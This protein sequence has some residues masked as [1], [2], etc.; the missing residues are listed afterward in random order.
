MHALAENSGLTIAKHEASHVVAAQRLGV[1]VLRV[2]I[3]PERPHVTT[4]IWFGSTPGEQI[5]GLKQQAIIDLA[6][7]VLEPGSPS[8]FDQQNAIR[9]CERIVRLRHGAGDDGA[10]TR[11]HRIE[12]ESLPP[13]VIHRQGLC[14]LPLLF[15]RAIKDQARIRL[16]FAPM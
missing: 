4:R 1:A 3:D 7:V 9:C 5:E 6:G 10:L 2:S 12:V 8:I 14:P 15:E 13:T 16:T 11:A